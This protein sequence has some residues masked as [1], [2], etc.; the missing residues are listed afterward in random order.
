MTRIARLEWIVRKERLLKHV[1]DKVMVG[2]EFKD[3]Q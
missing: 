1:H 2:E 3:V